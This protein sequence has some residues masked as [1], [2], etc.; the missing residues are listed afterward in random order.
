MNSPRWKN[1]MVGRKK[2]EV[3]MTGKTSG[4]NVRK[5][6]V[7]D[8]NAI[9]LHVVCCMMKDTG[10][11]VTTARSGMA[12]LDA[13]RQQD[14]DLLITDLV[15]PVMDG[16]TL[17][18]KAKALNPGLR[19]IIMTASPELVP[20]PLEGTNVDGLLAKPFY[21]GELVGQVAY[22]LNRHDPEVPDTT[23]PV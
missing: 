3:L 14:F 13:L 6:L 5:I 4:A 22:C 8:D 18:K 12:A 7:V 2:I 11:K 20:Q 17:L 23:R 16:I 10:Y 9:V 21:A 15:M 19:V 1:E